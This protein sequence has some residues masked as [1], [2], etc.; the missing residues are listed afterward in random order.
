MTMDFI[1]GVD[2]S[3]KTLSVVLVDQKDKTIWS[4]KNMPND[5]VGFQK[6]L[7]SIIQVASKKAGAEDYTIKAG[8]E[9]T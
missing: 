1:L 7:D 9:S 6:L 2:V 3:K 4:C 8:L 5:D